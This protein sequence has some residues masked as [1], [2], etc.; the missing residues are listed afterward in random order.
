[1]SLSNDFK[2]FCS[3]ILLDNFNDMQTSAGEIAKKLNNNYY[4]L[5]KDTTS[6]LYIVGSVGRGTAVK[7]TSDLDI[8]FDLPSSVY[9]KFDAYDSN[10]QS[11]L[12]Q[13]VKNVLNERYPNTTMRGD[14]QVVVVEFTEFTIEV[15]PAFKQSDNRFKYPDTHD[16]GSWKYTDPLSE[17]SECSACNEKSN[18]SFYDFCHIIRSWKNN[19]GFKFG[20]L[21]ID[22]LTYNHFINKGYYGDATFDNY[23]T[24]LK[25]LFDYLRNQDKNQSYWLAVGSKQYV[26]NSDNGAFVGK[27]EKAYN[28]INS[29]IQ[30][31]SNINNVLRELLGNTFPSSAATTQQSISKYIFKNTEQFIE[32]LVPVDIRYYLQIDCKVSQD[33]WR[34]FYLLEY[35][36]TNGWLRINKKLDFFIKATDCPTPYSI[37]W[38]IRNIGEVAERRNCIRGQILK[39]NKTHQEEHTNFD[40]PH[41]VECYLVKNNVCVARNRIDVPIGEF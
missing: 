13:E 20:G 26:Y 21:L 22:T 6:H 29:A 30:S 3:D 10:G 8:I 35:L 24:I 14:G 39:T 33:G 37:Y 17:Q 16:G 41:Y 4:S 19:I 25:E 7:N 32:D 5:D 27:A 11:A 15:V 1:M 38:K 9:K 18:H 2:S 36:K 31:S 23:L 40:G 28:K 34:A 12:L